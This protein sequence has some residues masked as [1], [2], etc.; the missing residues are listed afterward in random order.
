ME[1][2]IM[3]EICRRF[4]FDAAH[5]V[6]NHESKCK[7]LHGHRY[8]A[9]VNVTAPGLDELS[10]VIDFGIVKDIIGEWIN[11]NLDHNIILNRKDP[12]AQYLINSR[13]PEHPVEGDQELC[14]DDIF[15][16][17]DPFLIAANPT[18]EII[19]KLI[20][21]QSQSLLRDIKHLT[22]TQVKLW[23]TPNCYAIWKG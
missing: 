11:N 17:R 19:A 14:P 7:Y 1:D 21:Y 2:Q 13:N 23:E 10:R 4:E 16:D 9:E 12:L 5:R 6:L 15:G 18:A 3:Y 20:F 22:I 8:A